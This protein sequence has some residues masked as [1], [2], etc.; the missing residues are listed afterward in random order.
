MRSGGLS[1][2][3]PLAVLF[4]RFRVPLAAL[5][6]FISAARV[7]VNDHYLSDAAASAALAAI[8]TFAF[9]RMIR[10]QLER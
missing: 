7:A 6:V 3:F 4:P 2:F 9:G 5:P 8:V 1:L 10:P